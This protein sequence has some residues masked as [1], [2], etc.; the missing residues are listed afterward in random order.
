MV[1]NE[2]GNCRGDA[3]IEFA[4]MYDAKEALQRY[5]IR[6]LHRHVDVL[7]SNRSEWLASIPQSKKLA[8]TVDD[9]DEPIVKLNG[10]PANV[11]KDQITDF[12]FGMDC[13]TIQL[14]KQPSGS[15]NGEAFVQ[16]DSVETVVKALSKNGEPLEQDSR[17]GFLD[18]K[19]FNSFKTGNNWLIG[20]R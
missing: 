20:H 2:L 6:Y 3:F 14:V 8:K 12:F 5:K 1:L 7:K 15:C 16:F 17:Y 10:L 9:I 18:Y 13:K 19:D 11:T 4:S